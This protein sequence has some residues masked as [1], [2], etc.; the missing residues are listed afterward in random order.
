MIT[1]GEKRSHPVS[2]SLKVH[3]R[4]YSP[5]K[6]KEYSN[7]I[8]LTNVTYGEDSSHTVNALYIDQKFKFRPKVYPAES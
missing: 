8:Y 3:Y 7:A 4:Y 1:N 6:D 2:N 5:T